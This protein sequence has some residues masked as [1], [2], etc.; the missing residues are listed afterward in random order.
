[1]VEYLA[2][3]VRATLAWVAT[4]AVDAGLAP[5]TL[6]VRPTTGDLSTLNVWVAEVTWQ[7]AALDLVVVGPALGELSARVFGAWVDAEPVESVARLVGRAVLVVLAHG[8]N[9]GANRQ[10]ADKTVSLE[11]VGTAAVGAVVGIDTDGVERTRVVDL[12]GWL[13][14]ASDAS[15]GDGTVVVAIATRFNARPCDRITR[16]TWWAMLTTWRLI[17]ANWLMKK[18]SACL[19]WQTKVAGTG[20]L[21]SAV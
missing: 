2:G 12:T 21:A 11:S 14:V 16:N 17:M 3:G 7:A 19:I 15:L 10:T 8:L 20:V 4:L 1:M 13:A 5:R 6:L 18:D 9:V